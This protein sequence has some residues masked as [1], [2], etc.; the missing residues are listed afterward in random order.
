MVDQRKDPQ[1]M[2]EDDPF[3]ETLDQLPMIQVPPVM[4]PNIMK[5]VMD[6]Y[7][8]DQFKSVHVP[9]YTL[10]LAMAY[11]VLNLFS[12]SDLPWRDLLEKLLSSPESGLLNGFHFVFSICWNL[13]ADAHLRSL[14]LAGLP[15]FLGL[16]LI[17]AFV[18]VGV[19]KWIRSLHR[20]VKTSEDSP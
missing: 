8:R 3:I 11:S 2:P 16:I 19:R 13:I 12:P 9:L 6:E 5:K 17:L 10:L 20:P 7:I 14:L 4:L 15:H 1:I 18:F